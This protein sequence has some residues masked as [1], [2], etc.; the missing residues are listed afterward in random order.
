MNL[1]YLFLDAKEHN[2]EGG[3]RTHARLMPPNS[4]AGSPLWPLGYLDKYKSNRQK[5]KPLPRVKE[6]VGSIFCPIYFKIY[7]KNSIPQP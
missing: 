5:N 3:I 4:L 1:A 7:R 2:V 6:P